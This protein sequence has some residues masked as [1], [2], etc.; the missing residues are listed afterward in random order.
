MEYIASGAQAEI[1]K[2]GTKAIKLF[3]NI[4]P[5]EEIE[6]E[7]N[8]QRMAFD[9]GLPVPQVFDIIEIDNKFGIVMEYI[10]GETLG[11]II[12]RDNNKLEDYL[13]KSIDLNII[14]VGIKTS[15]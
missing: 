6:H 4:F 11:E 9:F 15:R 14:L 7:V 3:K 2:D 8:L 5:K 1:Y 10:E 12:K 13:I